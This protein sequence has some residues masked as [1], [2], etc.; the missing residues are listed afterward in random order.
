MILSVYF[1]AI[2]KKIGVVGCR[3]EQT[4]FRELSPFVEFEFFFLSLLP[5]AESTFNNKKT[6]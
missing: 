3:F 4:Q 5:L 1:K 6:L 2:W